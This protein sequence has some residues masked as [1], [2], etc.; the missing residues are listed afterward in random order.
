M[1]APVM[2]SSQLG[3]YWRRV[4]EQRRCWRG[5]PSGHNSVALEAANAAFNPRSPDPSPTLCSTL[6]SHRVY[7][8]S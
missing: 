7:A 4:T 6:S 2:P 8:T 1:N 3:L 5:D